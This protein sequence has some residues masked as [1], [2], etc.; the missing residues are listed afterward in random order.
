MVE[1]SHSSRKKDL[2]PKKP[3]Y[4]RAGVREYVVVG[5]DP[6][7]VRWFV[8][9]AG[10]FVEMTPGTDGLYH[11][12]GFPGLW[13]DPKAMPAGDLEGIIATLDRG[14]ATPEHEAIVQR[15]KSRHP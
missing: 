6:D 13:L 11:S 9:R 15:L 14:L 3:D 12:E 2:G 10:R 7:E 1:V 4:E 8:S 5:I